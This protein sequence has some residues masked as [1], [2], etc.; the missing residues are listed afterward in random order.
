MQVLGQRPSQ[1]QELLSQRLGRKIRPISVFTN[2]TNDLNKQVTGL[3]GTIDEKGVNT[4]L[5]GMVYEGNTD[6]QKKV[7]E[8]KDAFASHRLYYHLLSSSPFLTLLTETL[9]LLQRGSPTEYSVGSPVSIK[10]TQ[11]VKHLHQ[12]LNQAQELVYN[13]TFNI[14]ASTPLFKI[15]ENVITQYLYKAL[16]EPHSR[17]PS[18]A[19]ESNLL[20][21]PVE[22]PLW[23][24]NEIVQQ[25]TTL[26]QQQRYKETEYLANHEYPAYRTKRQ[27]SELKKRHLAT[28]MPIDSVSDAATTSE[29]P[30]FSPSPTHPPSAGRHPVSQLHLL[31]RKQK[32][33][34]QVPPP[35]KIPTLLDFPRRPASPSSTKPATPHTG[36]ILSQSTTVSPFHSTPLV[37][38]KPTPLPSSRSAPQTSQSDPLLSPQPASVAPPPSSSLPHSQ[39]ALIPS[40]HPPPSPSQP[41]SPPAPSPSIL[42]EA[43]DPESLLMSHGA[44]T[45]PPFSITDTPA[46]Q[47]LHSALLLLTQLQNHFNQQQQQ[48]ERKHH[49]VPAQSQAHLHQVSVL[50]PASKLTDQLLSGTVAITSPTS[51]LP[52]SQQLN[53]PVVSPSFQSLQLPHSSGA[54]LPV[55]QG[56]PRHPSSFYPGG[57]SYPT[58][59]YYPYPPYLPYPPPSYFSHYQSCQGGGASTSTST[60]PGVA[61]AAAAAGGGC[62]SGGSTSTSTSGGQRAGAAPGSVSVGG[63]PQVSVR[64]TTPARRPPRPPTQHRPQPPAP[65]PNHVISDMDI[66]PEDSEFE[67]L[68]DALTTLT[69]FFNQTAARDP[70]GQYSHQN[71]S[72]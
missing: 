44:T 5:S 41:A 33:S 23:T 46:R 38:P 8:L 56:P 40:S 36:L 34:L 52:T 35:T 55:L 3:Q 61:A 13:I 4:G 49:V 71:F 58:L 19:T 21:V 18:L 29:P 45:R 62:G 17:H 63:N 10:L 43:I 24:S 70:T 67:N 22:T 53:V 25:N 54:N 59:P 68:M 37:S 20:Q 64:R 32:G 66:A 15:D 47:Q 57:S 12:Q 11:A 1:G 72:F 51:S 42:P 60:G 9:Q 28:E 16:T 7:K 26:V 2:A 65:P 48:P 27:F 39:Q 31:Y 69:S 30:Q 14:R 50:Q 6:L